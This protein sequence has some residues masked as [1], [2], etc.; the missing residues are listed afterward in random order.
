MKNCPE[1]SVKRLERPRETAFS[2]REDFPTS[3]RKNRLMVNSGISP[4]C[5]AVELLSWV[6]ESE[7][8]SEDRVLRVIGRHYGLSEILTG[9]G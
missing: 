4:R 9:S 3:S 2:R 5:N 6:P 7:C 1:S 8:E